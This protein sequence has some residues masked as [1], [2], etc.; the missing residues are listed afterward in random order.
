MP[1]LTMQGA[2]GS[3]RNVRLA[4]PQTQ[5]APGQSDVSAEQQ[6][7]APNVSR[8]LNSNPNTVGVDDNQA[9]PTS[10]PRPAVAAVAANIQQSVNMQQLFDLND[11]GQL[12]V[13][14]NRLG[15]L[16][17]LDGLQL[18]QVTATPV[19]GTK[20]WHQSITPY[21]RN[22]LVYKLVNTIFPCPDPEA[23]LDIRVHNLIVY[24]RKVEVDMYEMANSRSEYYHLHAEKI[25]KIR[26]EFE[27]KQ[28]N[29]KEQEQQQLDYCKY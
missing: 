1:A 29:W 20:E 17:P 19:Q 9:A 16:Q 24:A 21:I 5:A 14:E 7:V 22:H 25:Y 2:R 10:G 28:Q 8:P 26:K 11:L 13:L 27:E 18:G 4:Q 15:S 6:V 23:M 12:N 3:D